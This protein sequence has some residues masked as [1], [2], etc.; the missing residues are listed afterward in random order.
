M[1]KFLK[2]KREFKAAVSKSYPVALVLRNSGMPL[3]GNTKKNH[4]LNFIGFCSSQNT[5]LR[6]LLFNPFPYFMKDKID[7]KCLNG[8]SKITNMLVVKIGQSSNLYPDL[9]NAW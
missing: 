3:Q 5:F 6:L 2:E 9:A 8:F 7:S 1:L 4:L